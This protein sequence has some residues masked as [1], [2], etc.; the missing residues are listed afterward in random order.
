[1]STLY[2]HREVEIKND[3]LEKKYIELKRLS[4]EIQYLKTGTHGSGESE[5]AKR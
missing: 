1:M 5:L 4:Q 3:E 2:I